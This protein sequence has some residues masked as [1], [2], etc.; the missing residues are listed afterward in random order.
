MLENVGRFADAADEF[1]RAVDMLALDG[2]SQF[3]LADALLVTGKPDQAKPHFATFADLSHDF[4]A[5]AFVAV[6]EAPE[7]GDYLAGI[8][9]VQDPKL[10]IP[11]PQ[12]AAFLQGFRAMAAHD[13]AAKAQAGRQLLA[14][15]K[16]QQDG[17]TL[18]LVAALGGHHEALALFARGIGSRGD[19]ASILW[20]P[21]MR[22]TL[23]AP[24]IVP[25]LQRLRLIAYWRAT[26]TR[27]DVCDTSAPPPFCRMI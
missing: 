14:L 13:L 19:W 3:G 2:S 9:A 10:D 16:D 6:I 7:T 22:A 17:W 8:K 12:R 11:A 1:G 24:E 23:S 5:A 27:P 21:S 15:P 4:Q 18:K 25:L 26:R 20:Y